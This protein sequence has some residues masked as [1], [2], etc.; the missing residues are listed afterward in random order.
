VLKI[1]GY[2]GIL[3]IIRTFISINRSSKFILEPT[4]KFAQ[5][6]QKI[7]SYFINS[8]PKSKLYCR[9]NEIRSQDMYSI[10]Q[11]K[12]T[13]AARGQSANFIHRSVQVE[14]RRP[15]ILTKTVSAGL[16]AKKCYVMFA[17]SSLRIMVPAPFF[18]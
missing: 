3:A 10:I 13:R 4:T 16:T 15:S 1:G 6:C 17:V 18:P 12:S 11:R 5:Y 8:A 9:A 2:L 14:K 7:F